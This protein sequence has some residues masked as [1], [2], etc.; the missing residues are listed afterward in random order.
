MS[1]VTGKVWGAGAG[2]APSGYGVERI[3]G[4]CSRN[5]M[6]WKLVTNPKISADLVV[7][8][9]IMAGFLPAAPTEELR[10]SFSRICGTEWVNLRMH[11]KMCKSIIDSIETNTIV[12]RFKVK[13]KRCIYLE[14]RSTSSLTGF[15][16]TMCVLTRSPRVERRQRSH[17]SL[18]IQKNLSTSGMT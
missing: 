14:R 12:G 10:S 1:Q 6:L 11:F 3:N 13:L 16:R 15:T 18:E 5:Q 17:K 8:A 7:S 9:A 4:R 2:P